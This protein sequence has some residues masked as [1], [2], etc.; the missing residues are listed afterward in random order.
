MRCSGCGG[1]LGRDCYNEAE[2]VEISRQRE[3][4]YRELEY[5]YNQIYELQGKVD[6]LEEILEQNN[7]PLPYI[8]Y[9][10]PSVEDDEDGSLPF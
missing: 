4:D 8:K 5:L 1:I 9:V 2:C 10:T 6:T 7:I 3:Q